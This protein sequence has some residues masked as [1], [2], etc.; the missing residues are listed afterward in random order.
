MKVRLN[1]SE[2]VLTSLLFAVVGLESTLDRLRGCKH[3]HQ[4]SIRRCSVALSHLKMVAG[5]YEFACQLD[6]A[7]GVLS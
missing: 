6:V 7:P 1:A 5:A 4:P 3:P 2:A